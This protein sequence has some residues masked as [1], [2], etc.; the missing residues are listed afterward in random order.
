[1]RMRKIITL[2]ICSAILSMALLGGCS[3]APPVTATITTTATTTNTIEPTTE[4]STVTPTTQTT[5]LPATTATPT[6]QPT[7]TSTPIT[8]TPTTK[9]T[10]PATTTAP[11]VG[12]R[13]G[14]IA[15]DFQ[16]KDLNGQ[17]VSLSGL[18]GKPVMFNF[19]ATWCG[20]CRA[21]MPLLQQIYD[22]WKDKG[23]IVL[24]IDL[25]ESASA[26][27]QFMTD[28]KLTLPTLLDSDGQVSKAYAVTV[29]PTTYFVD[30]GGVIRQ[31][32][33]GAFP[34]TQLIEDQ[35]K[36]IMP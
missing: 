18:R 3:S 7:T 14:N 13:I 24:E 36:L 25:Q 9:T 30:K 21:E 26:V 10:T 4:P 23:L 19:W 12:I 34:N 22:A 20:P 31:I 32:V 17:T 16:L 27:Q 6:T 1:M 35:L 15:T 29:I 33:R 11:A 28:N 5:T 2:V 8:T